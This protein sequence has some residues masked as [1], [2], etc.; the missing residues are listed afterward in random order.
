[1]EEIVLQAE[2]RELSTKGTVRSMRRQGR[3]PGVAYGDNEAPISLSVDEKTVLSILKSERGRNSLINLK[4]DGSSHAVLLKEI[5][6]HPITRSLWHVDFHRVSLKKKIETTVPIHVKGEA[7]GVK[8]GGGILEHVLRDLKVRCLPT[9]IPASIDADVSNLQ[10]NQGIKAKDLPLPQGVELLV[11]PEVVVVNI[12][13]P[14]ILEEAPAADAAAAA[15][16]GAA[17]EPEVIKKGKT[18][19]EGAAAAGGDKKAAAAP[20]KAE[21]K[22]EGK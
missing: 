10:V 8:L 2:K 13:S 20:A 17:A 5:Q 15:A 6:R 14:T 9:E 7:P 22:K 11:D 3:I 1:M 4:I 12:V 16:P 19:E 18:D 21:G